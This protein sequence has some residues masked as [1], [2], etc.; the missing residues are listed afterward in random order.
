MP[1]IAGPILRPGLL[2]FG[3]RY[4]QIG[5]STTLSYPAVLSVVEGFSYNPDPR[6]ASY[7]SPTAYLSGIGYFSRPDPRGDHR[8][9]HL[10]ARLRGGQAARPAQYSQEA[11]QADQ[12]REDGDTGAG[13]SQHHTTR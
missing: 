9:L 7:R 3:Y 11:R 1:T 10:A 2:R 12:G 4:L 6:S 13:T 5:L 8:V